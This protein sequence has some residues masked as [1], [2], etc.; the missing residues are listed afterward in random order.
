MGPAAQRQD[1]EAAC[2]VCQG[3]GSRVQEHLNH[4]GPAGARPWAYDSSSW[5]LTSALVCRHPLQFEDVWDLPPDDRI[6]K[7]HDAFQEHWDAQLPRGQPSLVC[8]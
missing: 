2:E 7:L 6:P 1:L 8:I 4:A 3:L 5:S